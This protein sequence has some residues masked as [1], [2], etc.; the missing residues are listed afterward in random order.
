[1]NE[2]KHR[3]ILI[4]FTIWPICLYFTGSASGPPIIGPIV[5][6]SSSS[7][8]N[9]QPPNQKKKEKKGAENTINDSHLSAS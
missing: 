1:M 5:I 2:A 8:N 6:T 9:S 7:G 4:P 3:R